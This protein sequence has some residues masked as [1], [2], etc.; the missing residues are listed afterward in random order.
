M[1]INQ[2]IYFIKKVIRKIVQVACKWYDYEF[3][4]VSKIMKERD[5]H[6]EHGG[7]QRNEKYHVYDCYDER[8]HAFAYVFDCV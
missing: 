8:K 5:T 6:Q 3:E 1:A 4:C 7:N 2:S